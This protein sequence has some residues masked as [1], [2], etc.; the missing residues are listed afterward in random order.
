MYQ[1]Y[2][3]DF[4]EGHKNKIHLA[5]HSHHFWPDSAKKGHLEAYERAQ[6]MSDKKWDYNFEV[7]IPDVQ[8]IISKHLNFSRPQDIAFA[9]NTHELIT[10]LLSA[11]F[12]EK[13]IKILTSTHE[14]HSVSR[15]LKRLQ[16]EDIFEID[17]VDVTSPDDIE[18]LL[19]LVHL[20]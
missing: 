9:P 10:K 7:L 1:K 6:M 13:K 11:H 4:L 3:K 17:Y 5:A 14:F 12:F 2:Y 19:Q 18:T 20:F 8:N 15:Q 16:E